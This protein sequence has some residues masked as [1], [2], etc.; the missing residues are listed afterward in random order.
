MR[1][2]DVQVGRNAICT[3]KIRSEKKQQSS[4]TISGPAVYCCAAGLTG[5]ALQLQLDELRLDGGRMDALVVEELL[6]LLGDLHVLGQIATT[7][8]GVVCGIV[9]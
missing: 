5:D 9:K 2:A 6:H 4:A 7:A 1:A 3:R 8:S